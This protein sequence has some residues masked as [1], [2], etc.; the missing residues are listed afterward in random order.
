M[1]LLKA[2]GSSSDGKSQSIYA[3]RAE[4]QI[5][6][7]KRAYAMA[8]VDPGTVEMIEAH[9]TGTRVGDEV[10]FKALNQFLVEAAEQRG[11]R[12]PPCALGSVK[13]MIGHTKAAAGSAG[14]IKSVLALYHKVLPPTLKADT[15]DPNLNI[16]NSSLYLN[17]ESRPWFSHQGDRRRAGVSAFGFGGSN[18]HVVLEEYQK[19]KKDIS[20]DG[21]VEI[22]ALCASSGDELKQALTSIQSRLAEETSFETVADI[23]SKTRLDFDSNAPYRLLMILERSSW[24]S[25]NG[26]SFVKRMGD[27]LLALDE[28]ADEPK[29]DNKLVF[30][31][32]PQKPSRIAFVFPGQGAQYVGMGKDLVCT[33]PEAFSVVEKANAVFDA[34]KPLSD[35]IYPVPAEDKQ[36]KKEQEAELT[37]TD[38]AQP[39]IGSISLAMLKILQYFGLTPET[40]CGH[41]FGEL[42]ALNAAGWIDDDTLLKLAVHRGKLM[43]AAG[44]SGDKDPGTM[45]AVK[46]PLEAIENMLKNSDTGVILANRNNPEQGVLSGPTKAIEKAER[47]CKE[48]KFKTI[49]LTVAAAFHT[50]LMKDAQKPFMDIVMNSDMTPTQIPVYANTTGEPYPTETQ[51]AK[52]LLG[53]QIL[54]PVDFVNDIKNLYRTGVETFV[55][56]GPRTVLTGLIKAILKGEP[57][58][59]IPVDGSGGKKSGI[60]DLAVA[61][62]QLAALGYPVLLEKWEQ[63]TKGPG[64]PEKPKMTVKISGTNY[65]SEKT[66]SLKPAEKKTTPHHQDRGL[67]LDSDSSSPNEV[68]NQT[69]GKKTTAVVKKPKTAAQNEVLTRPY[70][71]PAVAPGTKNATPKPS[72][73]FVALALQTVQEG[74]KSMQTL[75]KQTAETH[76]KFLESQIESNRTLQKMIDSTQHLVASSMGISIESAVPRTEMT[77]PDLSQPRLPIPDEKFAD[78]GRT[79]RASEQIYIEK[80]SALPVKPT[81]KESDNNIQ[82]VL[83]NT[84]SELTGYPVEMLGLDMDIEADLGIDS[85]KRVEILSTM[86]EQIP[87]LPQ[88]EPEMMGSLKT[89]NQIIGFLSQHTA[90]TEL[91]SAS[92]SEIETGIESNDHVADILLKTVSEL[93]GYPVEMLGLDMDI[94]ADLGIDSIKRVEILST[95]EEQIPGLPQVEP[96]MMGSLKTLNQIIGFLSSPNAPTEGRN[97][98][99]I[100]DN[101]KN[102]DHEF[103]VTETH[104]DTDTGTEPLNRQVVSLVSKKIESRQALNLPPQKKVYVLDDDRGLSR[105]I[106]D[107]FLTRDIRAEIAAADTLADDPGLEN[108]GGLVILPDKE[109]MKPVEGW[110]PANAEF[111]SNILM[112]AAKSGPALKASAQEGGALFA[113]VSFLD[114]AF[115]FSGKGL[116]NPL[117]GSLSALSKTAALEW[118]QVSCRAIDLSSDWRDHGETAVAIVNELLNTDGSGSIET[119]LTPTRRYE[120]N[121][122]AVT[123]SQTSGLDLS[124]KDVVVMSGGAKGVTAACALA[125]ARQYRPKLVLLGRSPEPFAEPVWLKNLATEPEVKKAI[126]END[127]NGQKVSPVKVGKKYNTYMANREIIRNLNAI[128]QTG[129]EAAYFSVDIKNTIQV[130]AILDRITFEYGPISGII[131]G[132]G[133]L[134]DRLIVDKTPEQ[135]QTVFETKVK[136]LYNLL[137]TGY[138]QNLKYLVLFS[139]VAARM[140]NTGQVDYAMANEALN[141]IARKEQ[142]SRPHCRV[143]SINWGPWDGGMVTSSLKK[144]FLKKNIQLI[145]LE[146]GAGQLIMEMADSSHKEV[147]VVIGSAMVIPHQKIEAV[148]ELTIAPPRPRQI[149]RRSFSVAFQREIHVTE[150][151]VL[152]SHVLDGTPVVP[153]ALMAEWFGHGALHENPGLVLHG[154]DD[155]RV[156]NGIKIQQAGQTIRLLASKV[157]KNSGHYNVDVEIRSHGNNGHDIIHSK[158]TAVLGDRQVTAPGF[159]APPFMGSNGYSRSI[160]TVYDDILFHG[161]DLRGIKKIHTLSPE[162]MIAEISPAPSPEKWIKNPLRNKWVGDPLVLDGAFQMASLWCYEEIGNVSLPVYSTAYRQYRKDYPKDQVTAILEITGHSAHKMTGD[163]TFLDKE[164]KIISRITGFEAVVDESLSRAF[165]PQY[166]EKR[167]AG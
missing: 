92:T 162:G 79:E 97:A 27:T 125:L 21:S 35:F 120:L 17:T 114:G 94:E 37:G 28:N 19:D 164:Q 88:V 8:E 84:V 3:P 49:R 99:I 148:T 57:F 155:M 116:T 30:Y 151:P 107:E 139:S 48:N 134:E 73:D 126:L 34:D 64:S 153:L 86:E 91:S 165:K 10:E 68:S 55:E 138:T 23:G 62:G 13:S 40:T 76:Q 156:L 51:K 45:M 167:K 145:P 129:A 158:A 135:F 132:A 4:G 146:A 22:I 152:N 52:T 71:N 140:G 33:F 24:E 43:A 2:V 118:G 110:N 85:I 127:F 72:S 143:V 83:L 106:V 95:M 109:N 50:H 108:A 75:Q 16:Q 101:P 90:D 111:L 161:P 81:Q 157:R 15:P 20:W 25:D 121:T 5:A 41:S 159:V 89:L 124:E 103:H 78:D 14:L 60:L 54:C 128:R 105:A 70:E 147:E 6:A 59:I 130:N 137:N 74:L 1:P 36:A 46:A 80:N 69:I 7:L 31:G 131:H 58:N 166:T 66:K 29:V 77:A 133:V 150:Y 119:G 11:K 65:R 87:G 142:L 117:M 154:F 98:G 163:F 44:S 56:V 100:P 42:V 102:T 123:S 141:K 149:P 115:G 63:G 112:L 96:E 32:G 39:A 67:T 144:E 47:L 38:K 136:G 18:F 82:N 9:G 113:T 160:N 12:L 104:P 93:T 61:L 26:A 53:E 122:V